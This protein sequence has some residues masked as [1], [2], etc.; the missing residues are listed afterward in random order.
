M[1]LEVQCAKKEKTK[2]E[3]LQSLKSKTDWNNFRDKNAVQG[4]C[5]ALLQQLN[6]E[7]AGNISSPVPGCRYF[8]KFLFPEVFH[9]D[10]DNTCWFHISNIFIIFT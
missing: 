8:L 6:V 9:I 5:L 2:Q 7:S 10:K 4:Q 3:K 1:S